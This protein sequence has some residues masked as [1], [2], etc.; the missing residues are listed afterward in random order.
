MYLTTDILYKKN[1]CENQVAIFEKEWPDGVEITVEAILRAIELGLDIDWFADNFLFTPIRKV[2]TEAMAP[3]WKTHE[4]AT[5]PVR[6]AYK[7]DMASAW[8][9]Y[10]E[11]IASA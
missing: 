3:V 8:E 9:V 11:V 5:A 10:W 2:Y 6:E 1:A 7:E 4:G